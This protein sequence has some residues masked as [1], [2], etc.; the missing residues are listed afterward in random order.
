MLRHHG[1]VEVK[2]IIRQGNAFHFI[3]WKINRDQKVCVVANQ[4]LPPFLFS[5]H[6]NSKTNFIK[7]DH[8]YRK[9]ISICIIPN[10]YSM[11][12]GFMNI[13]DINSFSKYLGKLYNV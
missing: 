5:S 13:I 2:C 1:F 6:V 7:F 12:I 3:V 11:K 10:A 8:V 9:N 4:K